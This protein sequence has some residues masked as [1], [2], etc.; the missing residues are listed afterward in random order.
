ML[1]VQIYYTIDPDHLDAIKKGASRH[2]PEISPSLRMEVCARALGFKTW[3]A[4]QVSSLTRRPLELDAVLRFGEDRDIRVDP[5]S[6]HLAMSDATLTRIAARCPQLHEHGMH[7]KY[8]APS[9]GETLAIQKRAR[10]GSYFQEVKKIR[11]AKFEASRAQLLDSQQSGQVLRAVALFSTLAPT[12][13][14]GTR[15]RCSYG[16]KHV[17]E[18]MPFDLGD[19]VILEP[20]YVSN[21]DAI[22]AAIDRNFPIK[23]AGGSSPNVDIGI[24]VASLRAAENAQPPRQRFA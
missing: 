2:L 12:K 22:I 6:L 16:I 5:L 15:S 3:A 17:A 4:M 9:L 13:G 24:T 11:L 23:A 19:G 18:R 8:F 21:V 1:R 14:V 20:G 7:E 10:A